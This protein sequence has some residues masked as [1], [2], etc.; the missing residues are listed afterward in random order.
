M[1]KLVKYL[2]HENNI[3]PILG[4][5]IMGAMIGGAL[6]AVLGASLGMFVKIGCLAYQDLK[7]IHRRKRCK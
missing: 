5:T 1:N 3:A 4:G 7:Q 2:A 6:G